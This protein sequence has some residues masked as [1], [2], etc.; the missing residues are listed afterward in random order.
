[1]KKCLVIGSTVCDIIMYINQLPK[2]QGDIHLKKQLLALGGCAYNVT[3][4]LHSLNSPYTFISPVGTGIYGDFVKQGLK[5]K[6]IKTDIFVEQENGCTYCL[7]EDSGERTFISYHQAEYTFKKEWLNALNLDDYAYIYLCGLEVEDIDGDELVS[8]LPQFKGQILFCPGPR[9]VHIPDYRLQKVFQVCPIVHL[10]DL[11]I[12]ELTNQNS[13]EKAMEILFS[14]TNNII[15]VTLGSKGSVYYDGETF[16]YADGYS[17]TV[18]D[19]IGAGDSHAGAVL[20]SLSQG[21]TLTHALDFANYIASKI[22][23]THGVN[24]DDKTIEQCKRK[25][26]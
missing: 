19:T 15:I 23:A 3:S 11:E 17:T 6:Q 10:N 7:V 25:L 13:V 4:I 22:V 1:M 16:H 2:T 21:K 5:E 26:L 14:R 20:A 8:V 24:L 9:A 12:K 18:V